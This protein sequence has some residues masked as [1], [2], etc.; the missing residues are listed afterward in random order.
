MTV[1][2]KGDQLVAPWGSALNRIQISV[3]GGAQA[4]TAAAAT[5]LTGL[6]HRG[7]VY[8]RSYGYI[9]NAKIEPRSVL[10]GM[11]LP[12]STPWTVHFTVMHTVPQNGFVIVR[13]PH[14]WDASAVKTAS[15]IVD[16]GGGGRGV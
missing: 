8:V 16:N 7:W 9:G 2:I 10:R 4:D 13:L 12:V 1:G 3:F 11:T 6:A 5:D 15:M 14:A